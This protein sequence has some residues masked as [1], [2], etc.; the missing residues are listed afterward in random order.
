MLGNLEG[1]PRGE[2]WA[3]VLGASERALEDGQTPWDS[4]DTC[5]PVGGAKAGKREATA[6]RIRGRGE[7]Q[8]RIALETGWPGL[9][10]TEK[11]TVMGLAFIPPSSA[12]TS[13]PATLPHSCLFDKKHLN[14]HFRYWS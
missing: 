8:P 13:L 1:P 7:G 4:L 5:F 12:V 14:L 6:D 10:G 2:A 9:A 3:S 11:G